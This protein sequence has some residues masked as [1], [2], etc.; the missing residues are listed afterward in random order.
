MFS[1]IKEKLV[2]REYN[3]FERILDKFITQS[4]LTIPA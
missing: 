1:K 2:I 4:K 3:E